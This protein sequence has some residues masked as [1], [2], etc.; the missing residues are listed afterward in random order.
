MSNI[1]LYNHEISLM[2]QEDLVITRKLTTSHGNAVDI[3]EL[4]HAKDIE[5]STRY[6]I[7]EL[8]DVQGKTVE[9]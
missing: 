1:S 4:E 6:R 5:T 3:R 9:N 8:S 2:P 7:F